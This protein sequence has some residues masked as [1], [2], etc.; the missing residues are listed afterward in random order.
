VTDAQ[1]QFV[2]SC[3]RARIA[4]GDQ[5]ASEMAAL[6]A[7]HLYADTGGS[8]LLRPTG[9]VIGLN[10]DSNAPEVLSAN[11]RWHR[12]AY[13]VVAELYPELASLR[14]TKPRHARDCSAC[15]GTGQLI[16]LRCGHC[17]GLGWLP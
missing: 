17:Q 8:L 5:W 14:P 1:A 13:V 9:E 4:S 15:A 3:I 12:L 6:G 10:H 2:A 16:G 11:S 7:L